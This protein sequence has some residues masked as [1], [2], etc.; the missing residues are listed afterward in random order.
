MPLAVPSAE[1]LKQWAE[2]TRPMLARGRTGVDRARTRADLAKKEI[3]PDPVLGVQYGQRGGA[4]G[5]ERMGSATVG[6]SVP[7]FAKSRQLRLRDA[8]AAMEA[9]ARADLADMRAQVDARIGELLAELERT[10]TLV[11]LYR[12][13]VLPQARANVESS[14]SSYRVG[15]VDFMTLVDAQMTV[16][17]YEQELYGL[18][19]E[20]GRSVAE[21]EMTIGRELPRS[22][23]TIAEAP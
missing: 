16:N 14:F 4:M 10:S 3:W 21:L 7:L 19:A 18:L 17:E 12:S 5:T 8:A 6:F 9:M 1:M 22:S 15:T 13:E 20:Y 2:D 23:Q 11:E